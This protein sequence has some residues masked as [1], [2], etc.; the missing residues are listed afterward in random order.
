MT[1]AN[2]NTHLITSAATSGVL[3]VGCMSGGIA[4]PEEVVLYF[5]VGTIGGLLPDL[6]SD[7]SFIIQGF[8]NILGIFI[9]FL[10]MFTQVKKFSLAELLILW[11]AG[12]FLIRYGAFHLFTKLT[13][14]R[15]IFHSIPAGLFFWIGTTLATTQFL[16]FAP[17]K[18]WLTGAFVF[19]GYL[20][21]LLLDELFGVDLANQKIKR[22]FGS[23]LKLFDSRNI[24]GTI[25]LYLLVALGLFVAPDYKSFLAI[26]TGGKFLTALKNNL[27][28]RKNW[29]SFR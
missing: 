26:F 27:L 1:M 15:G 5:G 24:P 14:H 10:V 29:F 3:A 18:A 9:A 6:D 8:F 12:Y 16:G 13:T 25:I 11:F 22:S 2:F 4:S 7:N 23:A 21:H 17:L 20:S 28:P 19:W